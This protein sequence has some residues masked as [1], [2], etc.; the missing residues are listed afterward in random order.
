MQISNSNEIKFSIGISGR[1]KVDGF[2]VPTYRPGF[3]YHNVDSASLISKNNKQLFTTYFNSIKSKATGLEEKPSNYYIKEALLTWYKLW[4]DD[5]DLESNQQYKKYFDGFQEILLNSLPKVLEFKNLEIRESEIVL[6]TRAGD[7]L[8]DSCSGGI[9][10]LI[11]LY[12]QIYLF[13][14][15][16]DKKF[17]VIIDEIENHLH[18]SMQREVLPQLLSTFG[19]IKFIVATHSPLIIGSV[20]NSNVYALRYYEF[21]NDTKR[22]KSELLDLVNKPKT[23]SEILNEVLGVPFTLPLWVEASIDNIVNKYSK[24]PI[25]EDSFDKMRD[26]LKQ[27]G[28]E[29]MMPQAMKS[30]LKND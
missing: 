7:Y 4:K 28:L 20:K 9:S 18:P 3:Y 19:N 12:W 13:S 24:E 17:T 29:D 2:Y 16:S 25:S 1:Q 22:V 11:D 6:V 30:I 5:P 8:L 21:D 14:L 23:A 15:Q 10:M 26:E 27:I